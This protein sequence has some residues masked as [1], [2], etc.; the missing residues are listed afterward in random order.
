VDLLVEERVAAVVPLVVGL[1]VVPLLT[2]LEVV[3][4][5]VRVADSRASVLLVP[6]IVPL[7][8]VLAVPAG[9]SAVDLFTPRVRSSLSDRSYPRFVRV[10]PATLV[11]PIELPRR[12]L[13]RVR[14][15][16]A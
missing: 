16:L 5:V 1:V 8:A 11:R 4:E 10:S 6:P 7:E 9:V 15:L 14:P 3:L 12:K 2:A 13:E